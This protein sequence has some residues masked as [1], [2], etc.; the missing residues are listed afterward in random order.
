MPTLTSGETATTAKGAIAHALAILR[1]HPHKDEK[2]AARG[3]DCLRRFRAVLVEPIGNLSLVVRLLEPE[4]T[5][6]H[7]LQDF[8]L[9]E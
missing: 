7:R 3:D 5:M 6:E 4:R 9:G 2:R 8:S 1:T